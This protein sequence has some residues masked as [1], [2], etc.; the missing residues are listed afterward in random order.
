MQG[1]PSDSSLR[2]IPSRAVG[3]GLSGQSGHFAPS[4]NAQGVAVHEVD[5]QTQ[6]T[7]VTQDA[8]NQLQDTLHW[9]DLEKEKYSYRKS[10]PNPNSASKMVHHDQVAGY[11]QDSKSTGS[12][13]RE[14]QTPAPYGESR[15]FTTVNTGRT[16]NSQHSS[17]PDF[18]HNAG[19]N[20]KISTYHTPAGS[21][22]VK[23]RIS[24]TTSVPSADPCLAQRMAP[25]VPARKRKGSPAVVEG[26]EHERRK[27]KAT[28]AGKTHPAGEPSRYA[29]RG[30][31]QPSIRDLPSLERTSSVT[32]SARLGASSSQPRGQ[33]LSLSQSQSQ[34]QSQPRMRSLAGS[35]TRGV[36][37]GRR[38]SK[39][40]DFDA[41]FTQ[42]LRR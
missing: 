35:T 34:T 5:L 28:E 11:D 9:T 29:L 12:N 13:E 36:R 8:Q 3:P 20:R 40:D 23:R 33:S 30:V 17:S 31:A 27:R 38:A 16:V 4:A 32:T 26:Y 15:D 39:G 7:M 42:E 19:G 6:L 1:Q 41:V 22:S 10:Y 25:P 14:Q 37:G 21:A 18:L 2:S 24:S